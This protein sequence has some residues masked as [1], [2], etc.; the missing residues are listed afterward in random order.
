MA[1]NNIMKEAA[2]LLLKT[3]AVTLR[4]NPPYKWVSGILAPIYTDNRLLLSYPEEREK[5]IEFFLQALKA[6]NVNFDVVAGVSTSG[7]PWAAWVADKLN[8]PMVYVRSAEKDHGKDNLIEGKLEKG[9]HVIV[10]ED[11]ISTGSSSLA[12]VD[13]IRKAGCHVECCIAIFTYELEK[14]RINFQQAN[15]KLIALTNFR[16]LIETATEQGYLKDGEKKAVLEWNK[17]PD[18]WGR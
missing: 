9:S 10:I 15:C 1:G 7:I 6:N 17:N 11:L 13:A 4:T 2:E 8:K 3:N 18:G 16:T 14:S 12:A 5:V